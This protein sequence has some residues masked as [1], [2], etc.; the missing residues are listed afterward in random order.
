MANLATLR[1]KHET[2]SRVIFTSTGRYALAVTHDG[3]CYTCIRYQYVGP[4]DWIMA[5][6]IQLERAEKVIEWLA[7]YI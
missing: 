2:G 5:T 6:E 3:D 7:Q 4:D 1:D